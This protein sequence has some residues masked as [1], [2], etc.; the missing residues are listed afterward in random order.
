[1]RGIDDVED[2]KLD[3]AGEHPFDRLRAVVRL[4]DNVEVR[5]DVEQAAQAPAHDGVIVGQEDA[6]RSG[7]AHRAASSR[8]RRRHS[9]VP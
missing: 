7:P 2:C 9:C 8:A 3:V 4:G 5:L 1:M 6:R